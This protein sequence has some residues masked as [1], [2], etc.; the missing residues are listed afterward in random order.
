[1]SHPV[2][3]ALCQQWE[4]S[5]PLTTSGKSVCH[6]TDTAVLLQYLFYI[7]T[8]PVIKHINLFR[9][10]D[11][12]VSTSTLSFYR[13]S[14]YFAMILLYQNCHHADTPVIL[15]WYLCINIYFV[16]IQIQLLFCINTFVFTSNVSLYRYN[17]YSTM[18]LLYPYLLFHHTAVIMY[19]LSTS[20]L[21][22]YRYGSYSAIIL[23]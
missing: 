10:I 16:I 15:Q 14:C 7:N 18:I 22:S 12:S 21:S 2:L 19:Q 1:M 6:H 11:T 13:Y 9:C 4:N 5:S 3:I 23:S 8:C 17:R 20:I